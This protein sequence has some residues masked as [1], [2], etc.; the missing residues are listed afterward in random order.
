[1]KTILFVCTG[2]TCRSPMAAGILKDLIEKSPPGD[3]SIEVKSAGL[4]VFEKG[5]AHP[6]AIKVTKDKGIDISD[7]TSQQLTLELME[8]A[9]LILT[10]TQSHRDQIIIVEPKYKDKVYTLLEFIQEE[11]ETENVDIADPFGLSKEEYEKTAQQ[12]TWAIEKALPK[13]IK[14]IL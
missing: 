9:D 2:N 6:N 10:M 12:L 8:R 4:M 14:K 5:P 11:G 7:H 3:N 13:I 1:M